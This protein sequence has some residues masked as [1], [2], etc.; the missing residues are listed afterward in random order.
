MAI[1]SSSTVCFPI[2]NQLNVLSVCER[3]KERERERREKD[4]RENM[5]NPIEILTEPDMER[6]KDVKGTG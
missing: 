6:E 2:V 4:K 5:H 1:M 3:K